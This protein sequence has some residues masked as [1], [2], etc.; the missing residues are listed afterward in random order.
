MGRMGVKTPKNHPPVSNLT[1]SV[2]S[3]VRR[4]VKSN[5]KNDLKGGV[6]ESMFQPSGFSR[7]DSWC[8]GYPFFPQEYG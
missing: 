3:K 5:S 6:G 7:P 1:Q 8:K 2:K 4:G